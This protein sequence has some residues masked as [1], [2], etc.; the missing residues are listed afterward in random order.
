LNF[1]VKEFFGIVTISVVLVLLLKDSQ[2]T[3]Q[4]ISAISTGIATDINVLQG[5]QINQKNVNTP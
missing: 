5:N 4:V 2:K 3:S 1:D